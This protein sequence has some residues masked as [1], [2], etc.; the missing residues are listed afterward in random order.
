MFN[1]QTLEN[2]QMFNEQTLETLQ[3]F[4]EQTLET[5]Q[6]FKGQTLN[7]QHMFNEH[8]L[9]NQQMFNAQTFDYIFDEPPAYQHTVNFKIISETQLSVANGSTNYDN[10]PSDTQCPEYR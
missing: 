9:D 3:M 5:L 1:E 7:N 6:M 4:N 8:T 10:Q 2:L